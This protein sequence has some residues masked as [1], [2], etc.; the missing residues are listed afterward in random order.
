MFDSTGF[1]S[2]IAALS[3]VVSQYAGSLESGSVDPDEYLP[4]FLEA[5]DAAGLK[6]VMAAKQEQL[7][8]F[9]AEKE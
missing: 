5:L 9:L 2:Q 1:E 3:N 6:D 8:A 4:Q 7:D